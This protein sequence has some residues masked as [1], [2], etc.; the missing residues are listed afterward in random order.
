M[1]TAIHRPVLAETFAD[2][3]TARL[4]KQ[5]ALVVIGVLAMWAA[6]KL[7]FPMWP[8]PATM[9]TF[10]VLTIGASYG[11]RLGVVTLLAY[12]AVGALGADVFTSSSATNN[13]LS[14]MLGA[15]G[16]YIVGFVV[17]AATMGALA[18]R[19][20]DRSMGS[21]LGMM[22]LGLAIVYAFGLPWM[23]YLFAAERGMAWVLE[24]GLL[25]FVPFELVKVTL[26]AMLFPTVWAMV[27]RARD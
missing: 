6:A 5:A 9:Q 26:A 2:E 16:G 14:Y 27:G 17:A 4:A 23:A 15:T 12:V 7:R 18:R 19:G 8:V 20:W 11:L 22:I 25:N 3:G 1:T 24:W 21:A 10:V 13:G